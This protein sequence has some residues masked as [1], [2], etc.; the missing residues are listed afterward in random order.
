MNTKLHLRMNITINAT[1][2][3]AMMILVDQI[4]GNSSCRMASVHLMGQLKGC[5]IKHGHGAFAW[6][7]GSSAWSTPSQCN[8]FESLVHTVET[9]CPHIDVQICCCFCFN[10]WKGTPS[11]RKKLPRVLYSACPGQEL[12][13]CLAWQCLATTVWNIVKHGKAS[14]AR[15]FC[16]FVF[17][18]LYGRLQPVSPSLSGTSGLL[19]FAFDEFREAIASKHYPPLTLRIPPCLQGNVLDNLIQLAVFHQFAELGSLDRTA[20]HR[21]L[22]KRILHFFRAPNPN[23]RDVQ[24]NKG[25]T[26]FLRRVSSLI[27]RVWKGQSKRKLA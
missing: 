6:H 22:T 16:L 15:S 2:L 11:P 18:F 14:S 8:M 25:K 19:A 10:L 17:L 9:P 27:L 23:L 3:H 21:K 24:A 26:F 12:H 7:L 13:K 1:L 20:A 5:L 4:A